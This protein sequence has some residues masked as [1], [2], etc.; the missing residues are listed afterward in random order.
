MIREIT[1]CQGRT[2]EAG[3]TATEA[4]SCLRTKL[5][6]MMTALQTVVEPDADDLVVA[7]VVHWLRSGRISLVSEPTVAA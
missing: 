3:P 4:P 1:P 7:I 6:D 5:Y 2:G